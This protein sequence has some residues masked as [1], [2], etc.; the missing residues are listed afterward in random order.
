MGEQC[1]RNDVCNLPHSRAQL[2]VHRHAQPYA[3]TRIAGT[4]CGR[5][6]AAALL[7]VMSVGE[8]HGDI[9][10]SSQCSAHIHGLH[11]Y[12]RGTCFALGAQLPSFVNGLVV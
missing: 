10:Y 3:T 11:E 1:D 12:E 5:T 8:A 6:P 4:V 7:C 9:V 2:C